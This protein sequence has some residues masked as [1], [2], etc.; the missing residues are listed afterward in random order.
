[1]KPFLC[2]SI[3][4]CLI[5]TEIKDWSSSTPN[6][7]SALVISLVGSNA[8][9]EDIVNSLPRR[10][11]INAR[12]MA[13]Q[14]HFEWPELVKCGRNWSDRSR[15]RGSFCVGG[16]DIM[17]SSRSALWTCK[18][19]WRGLPYPALMCND[20]IDARYIQ[21]EVTD[22]RTLGRYAMNKSSVSSQQGVA[23][24]EYIVQNSKKCF[25]PDE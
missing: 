22:S 24:N 20:W 12:V 1:M 25:S 8:C 7:I 16:G 18:P 17:S 19:S 10:Q 11:W 2:S 9:C 6:Y 21:M 15:V 23:H 4:L 13:V 5:N 14:M 3:L